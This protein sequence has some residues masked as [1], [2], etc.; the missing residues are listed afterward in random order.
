[1]STYLTVTGNLTDDPRI[2]ITDSGD[3]V[4]NFRIAHTD[5]RRSPETDQWEDGKR[6]F[7]NVSC[8]R[9]LAE[10]AGASLKKGQPVIVQGR[11]SSR[12][13]EQD[14]H[15]KMTYELEA[16]SIG[17]DMSRGRCTFTR[18]QRPGST[19]VDVDADGMPALAPERE[20]AMS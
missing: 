8:W 11:F 20:L 3:T 16:T 7:V 17:Y 19:A 10:N 12:E 9:T 14:G 1:M 2:R 13:Y 18:A 5:R 4:M 6:L 15:L